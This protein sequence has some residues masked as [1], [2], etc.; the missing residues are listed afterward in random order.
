MYNRIQIREILSWMTLTIAIIFF[1]VTLVFAQTK[2]I[3]V[4]NENGKVHIKI[5]KSENGQKVKIDTTF[6][7]TDDLNFPEITQAEKDKLHENWDESMEDMRKGIEKMRES[8]KNMHIQIE[9]NSDNKEDF[10]FHFNLPD[11]ESEKSNVCDG[12][13][14]TYKYSHDNNE[15]TD[16]LMDEDHFIIMGDKDEKSPV[17]EKIISSKNGKQIFVFKR[18]DSS[19]ESV[20]QNISQDQYMKKANMTDIHDLHYFPNPTG[21]KFKLTFHTDLKDDIT[22]QVVDENGKEVYSE[23]ISNFEGDYSKEIDLGNKSKGNYFLKIFQSGN[24]LTKKLV[25]N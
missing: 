24:S 20:K 3:N 1:S 6:N 18:T 11:D 19:N 9:S 13:S 21:G 5:S 15:E 12:Y 4:E 8:L 7:V 23:K 25:L 22:I 17:L 16:S 2:T 10:R 14:Y